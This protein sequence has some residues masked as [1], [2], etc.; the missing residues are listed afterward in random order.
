MGVRRQ[1]KGRAGTAR[2]VSHK[3]MKLL[4]DTT[5]EE[6]RKKRRRRRIIAFIWFLAGLVGTGTVL[7]VKWPQLFPKAPPVGGP[8]GQGADS[9]GSP[10]LPAAGAAA[11][12][13]GVGAPGMVGIAVTGILLLLSL[14]LLVRSRASEALFAI[15]APVRST[16][17]ASTKNETVAKIPQP[18]APAAVTMPKPT[19]APEAGQLAPVAIASLEYIKDANLANEV[20]NKKGWDKIKTTKS[21]LVLMVALSACIAAAAAH[22]SG[23]IDAKIYLDL[24][25]QHATAGKMC[26][27]DLYIQT[28]TLVSRAHLALDFAR[29][30]ALEHID[31]FKQAMNSLSAKTRQKAFDNLPDFQGKLWPVGG[32]NGAAGPINNDNTVVRYIKAAPMVILKEA[33]K[34]EGKRILYG[35]A[36]HATYRNLLI[37]V[38][39]MVCTG[40][41]SASFLWVI[42][43]HSNDLM[44]IVSTNFDTMYETTSNSLAPYTMMAADKL[45]SAWQLKDALSGQAKNVLA[46][47]ATMSPQ[48]LGMFI[49]VVHN[50]VYPTQVGAP[51]EAR[52]GAEALEEAIQEVE[53]TIDTMQEKATEEIEVLET[54][55]ETALGGK[56]PRSTTKDAASENPPVVSELEKYIH[57]ESDVLPSKVVELSQAEANPLD[58]RKPGRF[59]GN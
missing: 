37:F 13:L 55:A 11:D 28:Q 17:P 56:E 4:N 32:V 22:K 45:A 12:F 18:R 50:T 52:T 7:A 42:D 9:A 3:K 48:Q 43:A 57:S 29:E 5:D 33:F 59:N 19:V 16:T 40:V 10:S 2:N 44:G 6:E 39:A 27:V 1:D 46:I 31:N 24:A 49:E 30:G 54:E 26:V 58:Q 14:A 20:K 53:E 38:A 15:E 41:A 23:A 51:R 25:S 34:A 8:A 35:S 47:L 21:Q 36:K